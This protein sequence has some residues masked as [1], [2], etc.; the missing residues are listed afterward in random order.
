MGGD[1]S[2]SAPTM[3]P[4]YLGIETYARTILFCNFFIKGH[5]ENETKEVLGLLRQ[6]IIGTVIMICHSVVALSSPYN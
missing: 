2:E 5:T 4:V 6:V 3:T 1:W